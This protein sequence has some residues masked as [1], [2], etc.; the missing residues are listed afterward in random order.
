MTSS[1]QKYQTILKECFLF[2]FDR[3]S[4][5]LMDQHIQTL[6]EA[7][8]RLLLY[9]YRQAHPVWDG[10]KLPLDHL[11]NWLGLEIGTFHPDDYPK[12]TYGYVDADEDEHLIWLCQ[13]LGETLRRFTLAHELGH[14][15]LHCNHTERIQT[16][17][18]ELG[19]LIL[20]ENAQQHLPELSRVDPCQE[21][22]IQEDVNAPFTQDLGGNES[23]DH[24]H[25]NPRSQRELAANIFAAE[26]LMPLERVHDLYLAERTGSGSLANRF[27]VSNAA[28]L[29]RLAD[30]LHNPE[31][32]TPI[33]TED[34]LEAI[35]KNQTTQTPEPPKKKNY[36]EFQQAAIETDTPALIIAGPGSGKTSTLIGR[37]EYL[38]NVQRIP[39]GQILALTFSRK[40]T[41]EMQERLENVLPSGV[42]PRVSTF[43]AFCADLL[44]KHGK[45][46]GL[47]EDFTLL[48]EAEGYFLLRQQASQLRLRHYQ[49]LQ[50]PAYYF[51]DM[52]KAISRAKD[53]LVTPDD[54]AH[55]AQEMFELA[56]TPEERQ[57]AEK[58]LEISQAYRIY[59]EA[60]RQ[61]G[62]SDFGGLLV[63]AV[64]LLREHPEIRAEQQQTYQ[65]ILVDEFQ[66]VNRASAILLRELAGE[67]QRVWVVGDANQA[68][69]G[70]RGASP[71]NISQFSRDFSGA[72]ILPLSRN[73]RSRPDLVALAESFR[74]L[75]MEVG[76][77]PGK[78]QP[79]RPTQPDSYITLAQANDDLSELSGII[80]DIRYKRS[81]GY[82][83]KDM[84]VLC[85]TR[86]HAQKISHT[87][88]NAGLPVIE[89]AGVLEQEHIKDL[90]SIL[91]L[92]TN[93]TGV[94]L[95]RAASL[96]EHLFS[97][98]DIEA[99]LLTAHEQQRPVQLLL[100]TGEAPLTMST[101]GRHAL[102]RLSTILQT[103]QHA[104]D[105]WS[106]LAQY[107]LLESRLA[108]DLLRESQSK[109]HQ[110]LLADYNHLLQLARHY[111][112]QQRQRFNQ[113]VQE[114]LAQDKPVPEPETLEESLKG[115]L[116]YLSL[117]ILLR[118]DGTNR[119]DA[120]G[121]EGQ[122]ADVIRVMTAHASK[123]LEFPVVYMPGLVERRFPLQARSSPI[124]APYGM[125]PPESIG[126]AAH[127]SGEACLFYVG[128][129]RA[130][131]ELV[132]SYSERYGKMK[133]K[134]SLYLDAL[135]SGL[136][137]TR[138][139]TLHWEEQDPQMLPGDEPVRASS[140]PSTHFIQKMKPDELK[141]RAIEDYQRC[142]RQ[143]AYS[144]I[145][146]FSNASDGYRLFWQA[147]QHTLDN[148]SK[149]FRHSIANTG[150]LSVGKASFSVR[151]TRNTVA[152]LPN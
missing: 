44:R 3:H 96:P 9:H 131:D 65:H 93:A 149:R 60:L 109:R 89:R 31:I 69:Y 54:Y 106:V 118:Q 32:T 94:G 144:T 130:R 151:C 39:A 70:F 30:L 21:N 111:D 34:I 119:Q 79:I 36:D 128:I 104:P 5:I 80:A 107:L 20:R 147:M 136:P 71:A 10:D 140:Q 62:D 25:Y 78:N 91:L 13:N 76:Q 105:T 141:A 26:L 24:T 113:H 125:L 112:Q 48:D 139:R 122:S 81:N 64:R 134:R 12:G 137:A 29:T 67:N 59:E 75:Q 85:R 108:Y 14:A 90:L 18:G 92:L 2:L 56:Q 55:Q 43:H 42:L 98:D 45:L 114:A 23:D 132:L 143:Y 102:S 83:Y 145:Y 97:Q 47:R 99:L 37:V 17:L 126:A 123:G 35:G 4:G 152:R 68:I 101:D 74:C 124:N 57:E 120:E 115:F 28:L 110:A 133:Y 50:T 40:A 41:Q 135:E 53:E 88:A 1:Q 22:D 7:A 103:L 86:S 100:Y 33:S 63:S 38:I 6:A 117:L 142:P 11:V 129:T 87:L 8:A 49:K 27:G 16:I 19:P 61:H 116:E 58:A 72:H 77:E 148:R 150:R 46:I 82:S 66:D 51:P 138:F 73:Y 146:G 95:L 84:I 52:L 15:L 121:E 127:S